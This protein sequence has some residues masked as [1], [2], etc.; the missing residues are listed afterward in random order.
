MDLLNPDNEVTSPP[1]ESEDS[2][3]PSGAR[4]TDSGSRLDTMIK[5]CF[6]V[7]VGSEEEAGEQ[8]SPILF[9]PRM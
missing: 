7:G 1:L 3:F 8:R 2:Y 9:F 4:L 5:L 6:A